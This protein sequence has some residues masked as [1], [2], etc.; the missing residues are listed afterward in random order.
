MATDMDDDRVLMAILLGH[1]PNDTGLS[2][3]DIYERMMSIRK[4]K[5]D[6]D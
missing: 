6:D 3:N 5:R 2:H 1:V 4:A